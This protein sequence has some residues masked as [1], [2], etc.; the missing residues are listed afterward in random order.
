MSVQ[1]KIIRITVLP[2][3]LRLVNKDYRCFWK[4]KFVKNTK[5]V[6]WKKSV[7]ILP[8][9]AI[10]VFQPDPNPT[11]REPNTPTK[12]AT[13]T[14]L[15]K[16]YELKSARISNLVPNLYKIYRKKRFISQK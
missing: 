9:F 3:L 10:S 11:I 12:T 1:N 16:V 2:F 6:K 14:E 4:N 13:L 5:K 7:T 8:P 15:S